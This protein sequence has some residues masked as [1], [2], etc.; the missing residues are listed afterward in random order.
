MCFCLFEVNLNVFYEIFLIFIVVEYVWK[1]VKDLI[2]FINENLVGIG[3]FIV[4]DIFIL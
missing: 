2:I 1:D 3:F 4:I